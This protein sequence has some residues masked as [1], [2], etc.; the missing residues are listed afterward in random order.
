MPPNINI[1]EKRMGKKEIDWS[2]KH[3]ILIK[4]EDGSYS[5]MDEPYFKAEKVTDNVYKILSSGD[6]S[7]VVKGET[8]GVAIDTGYGA[9]NIREYEENLIGMPVPDV[10]NTHNHFDHTAN[11]GYFDKAYMHKKAIPLAT[12]PFKSFEG[13]EFI[14]DYERVAVAEG[15]IYFLDDKAFEFFEIP[16]HTD[17][18]IAILDKEDRVVFTGDEF[19][20]HGKALRSA[21]VKDFSDYLNKLLSRKDDFDYICAG[22]G[23]FDVTLLEDYLKCANEILSGNLGEKEEGHPM[24]F[25]EERTEDGKLIYD[26]M[27]PHPG[28]GGMGKKGPKPTN[29]R[30]LEYA[31]KRIMFTEDKIR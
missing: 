18:G 10:I 9:G 2:C 14:T 25:K 19:M 20:V 12:I 23:V 6:Y 21:T 5:P 8:K 15:D 28:D 31:G 26:R 4:N 1:E 7:Y 17:D 13:I 11:N 3:D 22:G 27:I 29:L 30:F 24:V 16:D